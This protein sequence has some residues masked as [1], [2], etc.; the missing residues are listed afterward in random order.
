MGCFSPGLRRSDRRS[1]SRAA[2]PDKEKQAG[3]TTFRWMGCSF[4]ELGQ[5]EKP[6]G[7]HRF[8]MVLVY[9]SFN[10]QVFLGPFFDP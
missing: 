3:G 4:G 7:D 6:N 9:F 2:E 8:W 5:K 1:V 10:Q